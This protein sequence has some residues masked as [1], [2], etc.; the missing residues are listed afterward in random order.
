MIKTKMA[1]IIVADDSVFMR[2]LIGGILRTAGYTDIIEAGDGDDA[3]KKFSDEKPDLV[4]LDIIMGGK[5]GIDVLTEI[6]KIEP[7]AKV[8]MVSAVG[9]EYLVKKAMGIGAKGFIVKP[10]KDEEIISVVNKYL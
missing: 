6:L 10:F 5:N 4:L 2:K 8:V 7:N 1:K 9:Q 3:L